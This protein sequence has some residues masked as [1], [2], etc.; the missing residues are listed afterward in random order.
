[1]IYSRGQTIGDLMHKKIFLAL[2]SLAFFLKAT[3][4]TPPIT[5]QDI[6]ES[7]VKKSGKNKQSIKELSLK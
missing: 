7:K 3:E 5:M 1:M 2:L 6:C 4:H